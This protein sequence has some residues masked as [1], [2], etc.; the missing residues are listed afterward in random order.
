MATPGISA[1]TDG[2]VAIDDAWLVD[3][4]LNPAAVIDC[5]KLLP[6][7]AFANTVV[8]DGLRYLPGAGRGN[9]AHFD[10]RA[11]MVTDD[12]DGAATQGTIRGCLRNE[13]INAPTAE[14]YTFGSLHPVR[15]R[16]I[17][18]MGTSAR[19]IRIHS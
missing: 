5:E 1:P 17:Y 4:A 8:I 11:V 7:E 2:R 14:A 6:R 9:N 15:Y 13:R 16:Y 3:N 10:P 12:T 18:A 19:G